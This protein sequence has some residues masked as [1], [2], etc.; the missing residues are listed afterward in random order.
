FKPAVIGW[1]LGVMMESRQET[2]IPTPSTLVLAEGLLVSEA[3]L[4]TWSG[5]IQTACP[6]CFS[7]MAWAARLLLS[8]PTGLEQ[9]A[10]LIDRFHR[11]SARMAKPWYSPAGPPTW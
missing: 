5:V 10:P 11:S 6:M 4:P 7:M 3:Q 9:R 2:I 8:V 1:L